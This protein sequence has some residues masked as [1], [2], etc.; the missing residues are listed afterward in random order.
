MGSPKC[1][2]AGLPLTAP[3]LT[4]GEQLG[5]TILGIASVAGGIAFFLV[6]RN[7]YRNAL[8]RRW[9]DHLTRITKGV[10]ADTYLL[11]GSV[12]LITIGSALLLGWG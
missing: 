6:Y 3:P 9:Y 5:K 8:T 7:P 12:V 2:H 4:M 11:I 10:S 1:V